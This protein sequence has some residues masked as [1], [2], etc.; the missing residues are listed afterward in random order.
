MERL[1]LLC[2]A[3][4]GLVGTALLLGVPM[5]GDVL[6]GNVFLQ[7]MFGTS[8]IGTCM[9]AVMYV[10]NLGKAWV[11]GTLC[12]TFKVD[13]RTQPVL[14][15]IL[16]AAMLKSSTMQMPVASAHLAEEAT[17]SA[18]ERFELMRRGLVRKSEAAS[19]KVQYTMSP[20][21]LPVVCMHQGRR[22]LLTID[23]KDDITVRMAGRNC[24]SIIHAFMQE[25]VDKDK[26]GRV[27]I[28]GP[29]PP[30]VYVPLFQ[31]TS[32]AWKQMRELR[33][34][35]KHT[36]HLPKGLLEK[37]VDDANN[38]FL[39]L[40]EYE[41]RQQPYRRG[42][43][44]YGRPG[45]G[46][47]T[48]PV[49]VATELGLPLCILEVGDRNLNDTKLRD[50]LNAAPVPSLIVLEDVDAASAST[51]TRFT[52][53]GSS[54]AA[55]SGPGSGG[56]GYMQMQTVTLAGLLNALD[57]LGAHEGH[58]I[59][60]TTN[61]IDRLDPAL[62]RPGR[63]DLKA[64]LPL[65]T[66]DQV[67]AM[68]LAEFPE[69]SSEDVENFTAIVRPGRFSPAT[70]SEYLT[71]V[72]G[73]L[74][75]AVS[76]AS[77]ATMRVTELGEGVPGVVTYRNLFTLF[78]NEG[79]EVLFPAALSA[80]AFA[81][82]QL[83]V[84]GSVLMKIDPSL[85]SRNKAG[86]QVVT[87][88]CELVQHF[89]GW[90]PRR[91]TEAVAFATKA[92]AWSRR[93]QIHITLERARIHLHMNFDDPGLALASMDEWLLTY[94]RAGANIWCPLSI[95]FILF[96][97]GVNLVAPELFADLVA[98]L[99]AAGVETGDEIAL[100]QCKTQPKFLT[101]AD[102]AS[103]TDTDADKAKARARK[104]FTSG[105]HHVVD[106]VTI[107]VAFCNAFDDQ[108][109]TLRTAMD[110]ARQLTGPDGRSGF[111]HKVLAHYITTS[112]TMDVCVRKLLHAQTEFRFPRLYLPVVQVQV[113]DHPPV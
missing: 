96:V 101:I 24:H 11:M 53:S 16:K 22:L 40:R 113:L 71:R 18:L 48:L 82:Q 86:A 91:R 35:T 30:S 27:A 57:G 105:V 109:C 97:F 45:T 60:M 106:R 77:L 25:M 94:P 112:E 68:F 37:F 69:A 73:D 93:T 26:R 107:A 49:V 64:L 74:A 100:D 4:A 52:G 7:T 59:V 67:K 65:A 47:T 36:L 92:M 58:L 61:D 50:L 62:T 76:E 9:T 95:E 23:D 39:S 108:G 17:M 88:Q 90:F 8:I 81:V 63:C 111:T 34:R 10:A 66:G 99:R 13:S 46:K 2:A 42:W 41:R 102:D 32:V 21:S 38:F 15:Q 89:L 98:D 20:L 75:E 43:I 78:W 51:H 110:A 87:D 104:F 5:F 54:T 6:R 14:H 33:P 83:S 70:I 29:T 85:R 80:P 1:H 103:P 56:D 3:V 84:E 79:L 28:V 31:E 12:T 19:K 55:A 44:L 72:K